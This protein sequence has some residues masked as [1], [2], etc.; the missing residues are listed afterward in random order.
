M[1]DSVHPP[2]LDKRGRGYETPQGGRLLKNAKRYIIIIALAIGLLL[3]GLKGENTSVRGGDGLPSL[4]PES[5][6]EFLNR[7]IIGL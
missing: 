6:Q 1:D 5:V 2:N 3:G 7:N 4:F